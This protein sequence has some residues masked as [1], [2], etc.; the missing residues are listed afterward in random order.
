MCNK[1]IGF[2]LPGETTDEKLVHVFWMKDTCA[3]NNYL[4]EIP[5]SLCGNVLPA[6]G[7]V[8][9][10]GIFSLSDE[11]EIINKIEEIKNS[12]ACICP[13]CIKSLEILVELEKHNNNDRIYKIYTEIC[14]LEDE[15]ANIP[16]EQRIDS[17]EANSLR[18][19]IA[20]LQE[21]GKN[22]LKDDFEVHLGGKVSEFKKKLRP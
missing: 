19:K 22:I 4:I 8:M 21:E 5:H 11:N 9:V 1:K 12:G 17:A 7:Y 20:E 16:K 13:S 10:N 3:R 2:M 15:I 14:D 6:G 18:N